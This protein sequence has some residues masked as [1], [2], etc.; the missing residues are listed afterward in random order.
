MTPSG[1]L[2]TRPA[3]DDRRPATEELARL[4]RQFFATFKNR[5]SGSL[6]NEGSFC[7]SIQTRSVTG[8]AAAGFLKHS[9]QRGSFE[10]SWRLKP[11]SMTSSIGDAAISRI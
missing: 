1:T 10:K 7:A 5:R 2:A 3:T 8:G 11:S 6:T 4:A 9:A